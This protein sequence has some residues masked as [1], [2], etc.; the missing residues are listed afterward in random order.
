MKTI[1]NIILGFNLI[2]FTFSAT[3]QESPFGDYYWTLA[4]LTISPAVDVDMDGK[5]DTDLLFLIPPCERDDTYRYQ[6]DGTIIVN[7]G[8]IQCEDDEEKIEEVGTWSYDKK[9]KKLILDK[10]DTRKNTEVIVEFS[11]ASKIVS[12]K[13]IESPEGTHTARTIF[14]AVKK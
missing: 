4:S 6:N 14:K 8:K 9:T 12:I 7:R 10:Y 2:F 11:S 5:V 3:A 1:K 13:K